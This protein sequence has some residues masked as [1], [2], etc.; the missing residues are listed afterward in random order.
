MTRFEKHIFIALGIS[1]VVMLLNIIAVTSG[2]ADRYYSQV[3]Q[4]LQPLLG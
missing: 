3:S 4:W 2:V 1:T